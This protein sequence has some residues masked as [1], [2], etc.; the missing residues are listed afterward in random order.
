MPRA[1]AMLES[2]VDYLRASVTGFRHGTHTLG[3]E[4]DLAVAYMRIVKMRMEDRLQIRR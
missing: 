3:D 1:K 2:F 4:I